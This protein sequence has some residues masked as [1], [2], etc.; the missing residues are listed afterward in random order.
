MTRDK[1]FLTSIFGHEDTALSRRDALA[2][3]GLTGLLLATPKLLLTPAQAK[4]LDQPA[5]VAAPAP[6]TH[7]AEAEEREVSAADNDSTDLSSR[8][9]WRRRHWRRRWRRRYWRRRFW[10]RRRRYWRRRYWRRRY[11]Y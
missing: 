6:E 5:E 4:P 9:Y 11:W 1:K 8:R 3:L 7:M 10:F 2:G